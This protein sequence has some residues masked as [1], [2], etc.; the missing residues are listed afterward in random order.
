LYLAPIANI[1]FLLISVILLF[2]SIKLFLKKVD[3]HKIYLL[4]NSL[5]LVCVVY[6]IFG[7]LS[8]VPTNYLFYLSLSIGSFV[9]VVFLGLLIVSNLLKIKEEKEKAM[10]MINEYS[11]LSTLGQSM[12]NI[13]HQWKEPLNHIFYSINNITAAKE[14]KDPRLDKII[15]DGLA[16]IKNTALQMTNTSKIFLEVY[17]D[18]DYIESVDLLNS[19]QTVLRIFDKSINELSIMISI[20]MQEKYQINTNKYLLSNVFMAIIENM[21][22]IFKSRNIK[23]PKINI[24]IS[25]KNNSYIIEICDNAQGIKEY[26]INSIFEKDFTN[27]NSTGLGLFLVKDILTIKPNSL[28]YYANYSFLTRKG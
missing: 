2:V 14:F 9:N 4:G 17:K 18:K 27:S 10:D 23:N 5:F 8:I 24:N 6:F 12:I 11:K 3:G 16:Q 22:K 25:K 19:I 7:L 15:D 1:I 26:L 21:I 13:S 28:T 20:N